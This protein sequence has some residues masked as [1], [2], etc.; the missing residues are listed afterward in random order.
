VTRQPKS[1][2]LV[3]FIDHKTNYKCDTYDM[4]YDEIRAK[5]RELGWKDPEPQPQTEEEIAEDVADRLRGGPKRKIREWAESIGLSYEE[6][7]QG[8]HGF[9]D[10]DDY[11]SEGGRFEGVS[12]PTDFWDWFEL[13]T[14]RPVL[15]NERG[16]FFSCSC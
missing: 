8:A 13:A 1:S 15:A 14:G 5:A 10:H 11:I 4:T 16:H 6:V 3:R 9:L 7:I 12:L 2:A